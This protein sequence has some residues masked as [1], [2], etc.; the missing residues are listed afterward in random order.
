MKAADALRDHRDLRARRLELIAE[1][2]ALDRKPITADEARARVSAFLDLVGQQLPVTIGEQARWFTAPGEVPGRDIL[3]R[4]VDSWA[5]CY[6]VTLL[7][8][9][10]E[11]RSKLLSGRLTSSDGVTLEE[12]RVEAARLDHAI[13]MLE[14]RRSATFAS[15]NAQAKNRTVE[16]MPGP[17]SS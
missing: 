6:V 4:P 17:T 15:S 7:R 9:L 16:P 5:V 13:H 3:P 14:V 8:D 12:R 2:E 10:V 1:R 11:E